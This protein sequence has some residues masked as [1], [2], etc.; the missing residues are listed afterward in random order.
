MA[1]A[2]RREPDLADGPGADS[3][4]GLR[5]LTTLSKK[6]RYVAVQALAADGRELGASEAVRVIAYAASLPSAGGK[7]G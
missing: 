4:R 1:R 3:R 6:H 5:E 2:R 7:A